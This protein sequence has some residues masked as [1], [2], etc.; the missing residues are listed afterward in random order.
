MYRILLQSA[1]QFSDRLYNRHWLRSSLNT[2]WE[3]AE[4]ARLE[5]KMSEWE[6]YSSTSQP[7]VF[8][9]EFYNKSLK[10]KKRLKQKNSLELM[11]R[12]QEDDIS[13]LT[14]LA[15]NDTLFKEVSRSAQSSF[16]SNGS[17][18]HSNSSQRKSLTSIVVHIYNPQST[19]QRS[20]SSQS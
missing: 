14:D 9:Y 7:E 1:G 10:H 17:F 16:D 12:A 6:D 13:P 8:E 5:L 4:L 15:K 11:I 18:E 20:W 2:S 19:E 3:R